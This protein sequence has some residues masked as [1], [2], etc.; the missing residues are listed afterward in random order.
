MAAAGSAASANMFAQNLKGKALEFN[1]SLWEE[2]AEQREMWEAA[3]VEHSKRNPAH[4]W[5]HTIKCDSTDSFIKT[6]AELLTGYNNKMIRIGGS[7]HARRRPA[8]PAPRRPAPLL[9]ALRLRAGRASG[10][11]RPLRKDSSR[12]RRSRGPS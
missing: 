10:G 2:T 3:K 4:I 8:P 1:Y 5:V 9:P 6:S 12:R 11:A 7:R